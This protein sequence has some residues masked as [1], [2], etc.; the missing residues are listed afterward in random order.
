MAALNREEWEAL[1]DGCGLCCLNKVEDEE[2]G[3][4]TFT[5][6][7][8]DLFNC[9]SCTCNDYQNRKVKIPDCVSFTMGNLRQ[10]DW[11]PPTCAY[12]LRGNDKPLHPWHY[13]LSGSRAT[14]HEV[15]VSAMGKVTAFER[16]VPLDD[17]E[18]HPL[19]LPK[20]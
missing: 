7:A 8:C 19:E 11:L 20:G 3:A 2:T 15:G 14:V 5:S 4:L 1:C 6:V 13:L 18:L 16:D 10:I 17:Y 9:D 12:V